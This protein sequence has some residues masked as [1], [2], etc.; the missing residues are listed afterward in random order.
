MKEKDEPLVLITNDGVYVTFG[1][2]E[3]TKNSVPFWN[4]KILVTK[5]TKISNYIRKLKL[6]QLR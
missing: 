1:N 6:E 5:V 4:E 2:Y 3:R